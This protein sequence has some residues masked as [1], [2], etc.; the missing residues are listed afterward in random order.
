MGDFLDTGS[1]HVAR[2]VR[3]TEAICALQAIATHDWCDAAAAALGNMFGGDRVGLAIVDVDRSGDVRTVEGVGAGGADPGSDTLA[4]IRRRFTGVRRVGWALTPGAP[5]AARLV[6][7]TGAV[8][9]AASDAGRLWQSIGVAEMLVASAPLSASRPD[10]VLAVEIGR[11]AMLKP[12]TKEDA[13]ML[14]GVL[15][16]LARRAHIAFGPTPIGAARMLTSREQ[17]VLSMLVLGLSVREIAGRIK[18]SPHTVHDYVKALH[19]KLEANSRGALVAKALGH[20][21]DAA[22]VVRDEPRVGDVRAT[23]VVRGAHAAAR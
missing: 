23:T 8:A 10:R 20:D 18:R 12:F 21:T 7:L 15:D 2:A 13:V 6:D 16:A 11:D 3:A 4:T 19:R 22:Q 5:R 14:E 9:W 1:S 17:E